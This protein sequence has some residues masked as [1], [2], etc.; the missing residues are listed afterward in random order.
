MHGQ[1]SNTATTKKEIKFTVLPA[2]KKEMGVKVKLYS[3]FNLGAR[4][5]WVIKPLPGCFPSGNDPVLLVLETASFPGN[6]SL[7]TV[8]EVLANNVCP[9]SVF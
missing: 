3:F 8:I 2:L 5:R 1:I 6:I 7:Q 4:W 9:T